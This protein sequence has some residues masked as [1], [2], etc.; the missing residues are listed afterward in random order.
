MGLI[1]G[2]GR[3]P[4]EG[5][6]NPLQY[7]CLENSMDR[8][9]QWATV[10]GVTKN[11]TRLSTLF[12]KSRSEGS[13]SAFPIIPLVPKHSMHALRCQTGFKDGA[14]SYGIYLCGGTHG[15]WNFKRGGDGGVGSRVGGR[16]LPWWCSGKES[17]CQCGR[18]RFDSWSGRIP[19][20]TEQ[21]SPC[22]TTAEPMRRK[23]YSAT[24]KTTAMRSP[25]E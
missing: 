18:H 22:T 3:V 20:A 5:N 9:A 17:A 15:K 10:H 12:L 7:S 4:G 2:S 6:G 13:L 8:G 11:W 25:R 24:R 21:L 23:P 16:V 14:S 19:H 1:P